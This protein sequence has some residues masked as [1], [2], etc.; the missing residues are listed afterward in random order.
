MVRTLPSLLLAAV[1]ALVGTCVPGADAKPKTD[2]KPKETKPE[3]TETKPEAPK[4]KLIPAGSFAGLIIKKQ[5]ARLFTVRVYGKTG[6]PAFTGDPRNPFRVDVRDVHTDIEV[7]LA[8]DVKVRVPFVPERDPK[9]GRPKSLF[10][11]KDPNDPDRNL[12]GVKGSI[13]DLR[14][15]Q[16]VVVTLGRTR[17]KPPQTFATVV[18]VYGE[19]Q[20]SQ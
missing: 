2:D 3:P 12:P 14:E 4:M 9:T 5:D 13:E 6:Q 20:S 19:K 10:P 7:T 8:E 11:K 16:W 17:D 1:V 18:V 15:N